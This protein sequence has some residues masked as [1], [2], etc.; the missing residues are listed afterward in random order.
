[1]VWK[2]YCDWLALYSNGKFSVHWA[3]FWLNY[4]MAIFSSIWILY[5]REKTFNSRV[6]HSSYLG[7]SNLL[8]PHN[9]FSNGK[10]NQFMNQKW[11]RVLNECSSLNINIEWSSEIDLSPSFIFHI[12]FSHACYNLWSSLQADWFI[13][14]NVQSWIY[15][16]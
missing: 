6:K 12:C 14:L 8:H 13:V 3:K 7:T 9:E 11:C 1:M 10:S 15:D 4:Q 5:T 2:Y 16:I